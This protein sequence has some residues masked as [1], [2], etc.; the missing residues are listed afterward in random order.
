MHAVVRGYAV[1]ETRRPYL[2]KLLARQLVHLATSLFG[3]SDVD[4]RD[5]R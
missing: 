5:S 4:L 2:V 3:R 1:R